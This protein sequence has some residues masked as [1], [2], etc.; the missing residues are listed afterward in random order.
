MT[1]ELKTMLI[2]GETLEELQNETAK[3]LLKL[4]DQHCVIRQLHV[5]DINNAD[6]EDVTY[7]QV[8]DYGKPLKDFNEYKS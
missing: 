2:H 8:I 7:I 5:V 3:V 4:K 1:Y 6:P